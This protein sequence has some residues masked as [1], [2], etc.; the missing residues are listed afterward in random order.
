VAD[1]KTF[2]PTAVN[3]LRL[4]FMRNSSNVGQPSGG[5]GP[6]FS[7]DD[8][9][10]R[11]GNSNY[12]ALEVSLRHTSRRLD[13]MIAYTFSKSIDR[14]S[15]L[16]EPLYPFNF[17]LTRALSAWDLTHNLVATYRYD[18]PFDRWF[19][20]SKGWAEGWA[21]SGITRSFSDP[22]QSREA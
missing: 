21:I 20:H 4:S 17:N 10:A 3:E 14:S 9:I 6:S 12:N 19:Q 1:T 18:L 11:I 5:V 16:A 8:Y 13:A 2:G 7:K 15:S 22:L